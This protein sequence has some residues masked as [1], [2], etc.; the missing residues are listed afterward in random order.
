MHLIVKRSIVY[1]LLGLALLLAGCASKGGMGYVK[2]ETTAFAA[3]KGL[4]AKDWSWSGG[5]F[6]VQLATSPEWTGKWILYAQAF[7][8]KG[9]PLMAEIKFLNFNPPAGNNWW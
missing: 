7:D 9:T 5:K 2:V 8:N 4:T 3:Q 1:I 6:S